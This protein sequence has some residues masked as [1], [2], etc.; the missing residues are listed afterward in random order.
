MPGVTYAGNSYDIHHGLGLADRAAKQWSASP[1]CL[2]SRPASADRR[3]IDALP[4][5]SNDAR[6]RLDELKQFLQGSL[7]RI[8]GK[9]SA[10]RRYPLF[11]LHDGTRCCAVYLADGRLGNEQQ[12]RRARACERQFSA[13]KITSSAAPMRADNAPLVST[14]S[15][16]RRR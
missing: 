4:R 13:A 12:R 16:K 11:P 1:P 7:K 3:L 15:S 14:P 10:R 8:S 9:S 2:S 6:P 5:A